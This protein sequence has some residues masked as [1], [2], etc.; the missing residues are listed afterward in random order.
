MGT[1]AVPEAVVLWILTVVMIVWAAFQACAAWRNR[2]VVMYD[3]QTRSYRAAP[4]YAP[5]QAGTPPLGIQP[6]RPIR[7][8]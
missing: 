1:E 7:R 4:R 2:P 3:K 6:I 5:S 8:Y